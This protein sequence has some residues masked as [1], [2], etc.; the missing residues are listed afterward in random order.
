MGNQNY[1]GKECESHHAP[2]AKEIS[3]LDH[4]GRSIYKTHGAGKFFVVVISV[5][6]YFQVHTFLK[7]CR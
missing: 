7:I 2:F 3:S 5:I 4:I 1:I 6:F